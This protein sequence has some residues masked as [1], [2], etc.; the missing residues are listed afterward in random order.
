VKAHKD[1][2]Y[3]NHLWTASWNCIITIVQK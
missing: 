3:E 2:E 1:S